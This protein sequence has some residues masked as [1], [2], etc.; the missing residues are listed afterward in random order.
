MSNEA[1]QNPR[2][3]LS[4]GRRDAA[5]LADRLRADLEAAGYEVWQD[6]REIRSGRE[7]EQEIRDGLNSTQIMVAVL[8]PH[9]VRLSNNPDNADQTDGVCLDEISFA[10]FG[11]PPKPIVPVMAVPCETPF[12][13]FRLDYVDLTRWQE[14]EDAYRTGLRRLLDGIVAGLNKEPRFR[15]WE[16]KLKPWDF[17]GYLDEKRKGF[18]G[19]EWLFDELEAWRTSSRQRALLITGD[20]GTGKSAIVAQLVHRNESQVLAYHCC[21]ADDR[22][23]L[24]PWRFIRSIAAMIAARLPDYAGQLNE[25]DIDAALSESSCRENPVGS[26][27]RGVIMPLQKLAVPNDGVRYLLIDA[28]DESLLHEGAKAGSSDGLVD[29]LAARWRELPDWLRIVATTRK[30]PDVLKRLRGLPAEQLD[31]HDPRNLDDVDRFIH[32]RLTSPNLAAELAHAGLSADDAT[33]M[34]RYRSDGNFLYVQ[35]ALDGLQSGQLQFN[36]ISDLPPGLYGLYF[37]FFKRYFPDAASFELSR[38][39]LQV[40]VAARE[41]L[42][43]SQLAAAAGLD[44]RS[45]L[46]S[47]LRRLRVYLP[48]HEDQRSDTTYTLYHKSLGD[49]L[50]DDEQRGD[51]HYC[52][53][54]AGH[55]RLAEACWNEYLRAPAS[56]SQYAILHLPTHLIATKRWDQLE[57]ILTDMRFVEAKCLADKA[58]ELMRDYQRALVSLP[59]QYAERER[60]R[61]ESLKKYGESLAKY[62]R[63]HEQGCPLPE[64]PETKSVL[65]GIRRAEVK[66]SQRERDQ[67]G[68]QAPQSPIQEFASFVSTHRHLLKS[69]PQLTVEQ[70]RNHMSGGAIVEQADALLKARLEPWLARDP[71]PTSLANNSV[72]SG[73]LRGHGYFVDCV[74]ISSDGARAVSVSSD[75]RVWDVTSGECLHVLPG[76][77]TG[78]IS[79]DGNWGTAVCDDHEISVYELST[80]NCLC[81]LQ[82]HH[83]TVTDLAISSDGGRVI[84]SSD[85]GTIGVWDTRNC[86]LLRMLEGHT[87]GVFA[88]A[89]TAEGKFAASG[90]QDC[91]LRIWNV[92]SGECLLTL[93]GHEDII[94]DIAITPDGSLAVTSSR[95]SSIRVWDLRQGECLCEFDANTKDCS[96]HLDGL[97]GIAITPDGGVVISGSFDKTIRVW[98]VQ[99]GKCVRTLRGHIL[100]VQDVSVTA[101]GCIAVSAGGDQELRV[102]NISGE[103]PPTQAG[104]QGRIT[105][106]E[107]T[108]NGKT[109]VSASEDH[110]LCVWD[111]LSGRCVHTL[112]GHEDGVFDVAL[113]PDGRTAVST[114]KDQTLRVWDLNTGSC[115]QCI[116]TGANLISIKMTPDGRHAVSCDFDHQGQIWD[117][118]IGKEVDALTEK[119]GNLVFQN[120]R[121]RSVYVW[122]FDQGRMT[123]SIELKGGRSGIM[124]I[125]VAPNG[126]EIVSAG[127]DKSVC[128]WD[129]DSGICLHTLAGHTA[130]VEAVDLTPDGRLVVSAGGDET[131]RVWDYTSGRMIAT[132][133]IGGVAFSIAATLDHR[134]AVG[135]WQGQIQFLALRNWP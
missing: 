50:T 14:S 40:V 81:S 132:H 43:E 17:A 87:G 29:L 102:W 91:L 125:A 104:H 59:D 30:H 23:T 15:S 120:G 49:W 106:L 74:D 69:C 61:G 52:D 31:A 101:D 53:P 60:Q 131:V 71:R 127:A 83:K 10:R 86:E 56:L 9:A 75:L 27:D 113:A 7:W 42:T 70:A 13:I 84:S 12:S 93:R 21:R 135:D 94:R 37:E 90:G 16:Q 47:A 99:N 85:D 63:Q 128:I 67:L 51:V 88:V 57:A 124:D 22:E 32:K 46:A 117:L 25:V 105:A 122:N 92:A 45:E 130:S 80:G 110:L 96:E 18:I 62:A 103:Y 58:F 115:I 66:S 20:P 112:E 76:T 64:P 100:S 89:V 33:S 8:S 55:E 111:A 26:F 5:K 82:G 121:S 72:V 34:L 54:I 65:N 77:R 107:F 97:T 109:L 35:Q 11:R 79:S 134:F 3:F 95:D 2:L 78:A 118:T 133:A 119:R 24:A 108:A 98:D 123:R 48:P 28:L 41:P 4:Y 6:S 126:R 114:A 39:L 38:R 1:K 68:A 116:H 36:T 19:R 44:E 129:M 73:T